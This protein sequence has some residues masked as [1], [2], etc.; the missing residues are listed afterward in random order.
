MVKKY[1]HNHAPKFYVRLASHP[2]N[3]ID[4][5]TVYQ[6]SIYGRF[7]DK[8]GKQIFW[9]CDCYTFTEDRMQIHIY[10]GSYWKN[11]FI[12]SNHPCYKYVKFALKKLGKVPKVQR[13]TITFTDCQNLMKAN[14]HHKKGSG[15]RICTN[16]INNPLRWNEITELAHWYGKG[17][18]SVVGNSI[19]V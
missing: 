11:I 12:D 14:A 4:D 3:F 7:Q 19:P 6:G 13:E 16:Q 9:V 17:N 15:S 2:V 18:A 10:T 5:F 8:T 1:I